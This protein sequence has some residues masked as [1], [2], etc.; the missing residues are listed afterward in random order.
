[1]RLLFLAVGVLAQR[2]K[3]FDAEPDSG[4]AVRRTPDGCDP[5]VTATSLLTDPVFACAESFTDEASLLARVGQ[6][7][8]TQVN[9]VDAGDVCRAMRRGWWRTSRQ[10]LPLVAD[11]E[12]VRIRQFVEQ[13]RAGARD[14]IALM[15]PQSERRPMDD[16]LTLVTPACQWAQNMSHVAIAV[17]YSPKKHG[18]VSVA[19]VMVEGRQININATHVEVRAQEKSSSSSSTRTFKRLTLFSFLS[20]PVSC[21]QFDA[22]ARGKPLRFRLELELAAD[23]VPDGS[24][25]S[26]DSPGR[27]TLSLIKYQ[28]VRWRTLAKGKAKEGV[29]RGPI[30]T[31]YEK[32]EAFGLEWAA[33]EMLQ[34]KDDDNDAKP[35]PAK[36]K[37]KQ[38]S[39][40]SPPPQKPPKDAGAEAEAAKPKVSKPKKAKA[41]KAAEKEKSKSKKKSGGGWWPF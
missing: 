3:G 40:P 21:V 5:S 30:T 29:R 14:V 8:C 33:D 32:Q 27:L 38:P 41:E 20:C 34:G 9:S 16:E 28:K 26:V 39:P 37:P 24:T 2:E 35:A 6:P 7:A 4:G 22:L 19:S 12:K 1:M 13:H 25:W 18:P 11:D 36:P 23:I 17:R 10:L 31:W 15:R